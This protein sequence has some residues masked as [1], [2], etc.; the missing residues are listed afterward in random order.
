MPDSAPPLP[1]SEAPFSFTFSP[2]VPDLLARLR[3]SLALTTYQAGK[4]LVISPQGERLVQLARTFP[5]P[6]GLAVAGHGAGLRLALATR[7]TVEELTNAPT[8]A[9][10]YPRQRDTYDA[11]L[12]PRRT[13]HTG[14]LDLHDLAYTPA[15]LLAVNTRFS[16]LARVGRGPH[17]FAP[18]WTP[19]FVS[20]LDPSD[21]CHLNGLAT[22]AD[23][24]PR[25]VTALG[26]TDAPRGWSDGRLSGGVVVDVESGETVVAGLAMPHSPRLVT[27]TDGG[28][29]LWLLNSAEGTLGRVD[30]GAGAYEPV[31]DVGGFGRGLAQRGDYLFVGVSKIREAS[32]FAG[33]PV[34]ERSRE[35]GVCVV[36]APT[37]RVAGRV[38]YRASV[39]EVYDVAVLPEVARPG[40]VGPS[41]DV[42]ARAVAVEGGG[43]WAAD[44][45]PTSVAAPG[46]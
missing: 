17:S 1:P 16:C 31:C 18:V 3:C 12:V 9:A 4:V 27:G 11:L 15:G 2:E 24:R 32:T 40:L 7:H 29:G 10:A 23:R 42:A 41:M 43:W 8:L 14:P 28:D 6:M 33:L 13:H 25:Y 26:A 19:P 30:V 44:A 38:Q 20:A 34:S 22:D 45:P 21:R 37:G 36:H 39:E 35:A 46:A 5:Q